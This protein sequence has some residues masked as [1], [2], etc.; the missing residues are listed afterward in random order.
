MNGRDLILGAL[1][2]AAAGVLLA[3][4]S[5]KATRK[6]IKK[7]SKKI[8]KAS[9]LK[10]SKLANTVGSTAN[11][12]ATT[13]GSRANEIA[14]TVK[15]KTQSHVVNAAG[16]VEEVAGNVKSKVQNL[17]NE[18]PVDEV[19]AQAKARVEHLKEVV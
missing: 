5:G 13:V 19:K 4:K 2:G 10:A 1:V 3:P 8:A 14:S 6:E 15:N 11:E 18:V 16:V 9:Q 12:L 7:Q 17:T